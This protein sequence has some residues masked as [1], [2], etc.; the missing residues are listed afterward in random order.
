MKKK[1]KTPCG[2]REPG[3]KAWRM[4]SASDFRARRDRLGRLFP[5]PVLFASGD[6]VF[7]NVPQPYPF[8]ASSH[9][10]Y[11]AGWNQS[12]AWL[13]LENG[14]A[15]L[16]YDFPSVEH[17]V[18]EGAGPSAELLK[19]RYGFD[20][21][22]PTSQLPTAAAAVGG[23]ALLTEAVIQLRLRHDKA[24]QAQL[25]H[26]VEMSQRAHF[27]AM[28]ATRP[29]RREFQILATLLVSVTQEGGRP[30]FNPIVST[31]GEVLHNPHTDGTL[32]QGDLLLVDFGAE[33]EEGWAGDLTRT[34]P[35]RTVFSPRQAEIYEVVLR[36]QKA[37]VTA[38]RP[39][40][41]YRD[42]HRAACVTM[43]E[44]LCQLGLLRGEPE[45]L[46]ERGAHALFFPHG[47]GHLLG[48]DVHDMEDLGD[49][50]GY[51]PGRRRS[52]Q[53][54]LSYL[55]L[56]RP[57]EAGMAVTVEPGFYWIPQL[58]DNPER[59]GPFHD[60]LDMKVVQAYRGAVRGIRIEDDLLIEEDGARN[61]SSGL[62]KE[63]T[64][65]EIVVNS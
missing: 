34:F 53:F 12:H 47:V 48:L 51:A 52:E 55:R 50:A 15:T 65:L 14:T 64:E 39:G 59:T 63:L 49:L 46:V 2:R 41:E 21:I 9:F 43:T 35:V 29:E 56:N 1:T 3:R 58:L 11:F 62:P 30:S 60:C 13:G 16:F 25:Q 36:A 23:N 20:R 40:T 31:A 19:E 28:R 57:L 54:G 4:T 18:W 44:G 61:L 6:P 26:A 38:C 33:T 7:R 17:A 37:A 22:L 27:Q 42:V 24:A 45:T 10:L 8:R 5:G 32:H